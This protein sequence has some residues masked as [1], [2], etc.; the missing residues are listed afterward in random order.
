MINNPIISELD[1]T[2]KEIKKSQMKQD[3]TNKIYPYLRDKINDMGNGLNKILKET[4]DSDTCDSCL[5]AESRD[6]FGGFNRSFV[7]HYL[8]FFFDYFLKQGD[9]Y[10]EDF[11]IPTMKDFLVMINDIK[12]IDDLEKTEAK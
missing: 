1:M 9:L 8:L 3:F 4:F 7:I 11:V 10:F 6:K 2:I 12:I 5:F